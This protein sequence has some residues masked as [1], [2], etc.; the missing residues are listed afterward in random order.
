MPDANA[1]NTDARMTVIEVQLAK[2]LNLLENQIPP[3]APVPDPSLAAPAPDPGPGFFHNAA[4]ATKSVLRPNPPFVFDGDRTQGRAF[5]H[6]VRTYARPVPEAFARR[7]AFRR[8]TRLLRHVLYGKGLGAAL[9][10][11]TLL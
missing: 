3:A 1:A 4:P 6:A 11:A 2:V 8:K 9:G 10:G 7:T 5:L